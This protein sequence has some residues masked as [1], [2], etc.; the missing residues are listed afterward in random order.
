MLEDG[1]FKNFD[2]KIVEKVLKKKKQSLHKLNPPKVFK[3]RSL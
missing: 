2:K 3:I 1:V